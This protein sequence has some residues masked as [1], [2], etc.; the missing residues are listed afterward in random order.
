MK[1]L[2]LLAVLLGG[3][4]R[5][6][7]PTAPDAGSVRIHRS[8]DLKTAVFSAYPEFRGARVV[9]GGVEL[10]RT[11][12]RLVPLPHA[13]EV[14]AKNGF[15]ITSD[16]GSLSATRAPYTVR[17]DGP[18]LRVA[19]PI[20][21]EDIGKLLNAPLTMTT[22]QL[23]LWLPKPAGATVLAEH[24]HLRLVYEASE[25][26]AQ[27]LAWQMVD[28]NSQGSWKVEAWP[29]GYERIRRPDAGGGG[30]PVAYSI[31]LVDTNTT[32]RIALRR[33]AGW[34][35]LDYLLRTEELR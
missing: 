16:G 23:G 24:F 25:N 21:E 8:T 27:Y 17:I 2:W 15:D 12:D 3:C 13:R 35:E 11:V 7:G 1:G 19:L 6:G 20:F 30:T 10:V 28:L 32:A 5:C 4:S 22:E 29:E 9:T 31:S 34:V 26:R 14:I 18:Q 33:D